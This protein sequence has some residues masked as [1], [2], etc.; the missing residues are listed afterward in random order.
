[1]NKKGGIMENMG[2]RK[3]TR[4]PGVYVRRGVQRKGEH[5]GKVDLCF[6]ISYK[7]GHESY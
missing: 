3:R 5:E 1:M 6:D 2:Q 7:K 4:F